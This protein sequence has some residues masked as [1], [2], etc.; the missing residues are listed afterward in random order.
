MGELKGKILIS[1]LFCPV[2]MLSLLTMMEKRRKK[3]QK[4]QFHFRRKTMKQVPTWELYFE[5]YVRIFQ[6]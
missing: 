4:Q 1:L 6:L 2:I 5:L 3:L